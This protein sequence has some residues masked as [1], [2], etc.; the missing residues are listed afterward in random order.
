MRQ[1]V[2]LVFVMLILCGCSVAGDTPSVG[3]PVAGAPAVDSIQLGIAGEGGLLDAVGLDVVTP[4]LGSDGAVG[5]ILGGGDQGTL[6][7]IVPTLPVSTLPLDG[8][9]IQISQSVP[10]LGVSGDGGLGEDLLGY[11]AVGGLVGTESSLVP[12]LL[13]GGG[14]AP[15]GN[16]VPEGMAPLS[17]LGDALEAVVVSLGTSSRENNLS[18]LS[19]LLTPLLLQLAGTSDGAGI[20]LP[21]PSTAVIL[22]PLEPVL[23]PV[24]NTV[25][26]IAGIQL[27]NGTTVGDLLNTGLTAVGVANDLL[28]LEKVTTPLAG[29]LPL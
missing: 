12:V 3:A 23:V 1:L 20:P 13:A 18:D 25:A 21:L 17:P 2:G 24:S 22:D 14:T 19:P 26:N 29:V 15:L 8:V 7:G 5:H 9:A 28:P 10:A 11:D 27:P 4:L 6:G 16:V